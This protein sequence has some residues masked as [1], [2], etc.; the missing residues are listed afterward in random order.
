MFGFN[1]HNVHSL[2]YR[3]PV[4]GKRT[5]CSGSIKELTGMRLDTLLALEE[6]TFSSLPPGEGAPD[7][8]RGLGVKKWRSS[9]LSLQVWTASKI[10]QE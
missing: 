3:Y 7:C 4:N 5:A 10:L 2:P 6:N 1:T 9:W 8:N